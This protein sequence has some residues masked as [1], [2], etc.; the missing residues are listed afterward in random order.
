MSDPAARE[1]AERAFEYRYRF[2]TAEFDEARFQLYVDGEPVEVERRALEVLACLLRH[3]GE[4]V[5]K[6]ELFAQVWAGRVTVD[7][8]LPN[9]VNKLRKALG[10]ANAELLATQ[11]R[12]GYRLDGMRE[13]VVVRSRVAAAP[14]LRAGQPVAQRAHFVLRERLGGSHGNEVWLGEHLKT[15]ERRVYKY[16]AGSAGLRGLRR[17][18]TLARLLATAGEA[19]RSGFAR[20]LDWHFEDAPFFLEYAWHGQ[21]LLQWSRTHLQGM[22]RDQRLQLFLQF[23]DAVAAA[24]QFGVL[25]KDIKP[26]NILIAA[27]DDGWHARLADFGSGSLLDPGRL[28]ELGITRHD[29]AAT[30]PAG[31][32]AGSGT[33]LYLPPEVVAGGPQTVQGDVYALGLVLYQLLAG[34]P[35]RPMAPGWEKDIDDALLREDIALATDGDPAH[36]LASVPELAA[37]LRRLQRRREDAARAAEAQARARRDRE[38]L[39]RARARRPLVA[40]SMAILALGLATSLWFHHRA[41]QAG[42]VAQL[43]LEKATALNEFIGKDVIGQA[44]PLIAGGGAD[45]P[46]REVLLAARERIGPRFASQPRVAAA[47][48]ISLAALFNGI[49]MLAP[50]EDEV[51]KAL[52]LLTREHGAAGLETLKAQASLAGVLTRS[53]RFDEALQTLRQLD[54]GAAGHPEPEVDAYR[55]LAWGNYHGNKGDAERAIPEFERGARLLAQYRPEQT[56]KLD[57]VRLDLG[58]LYNHAERPREAGEL[59]AGLI[60]EI[61]R[62][63]RRNPLSLAIARQVLADARSRQGQYAQAQALLLQAQKD[64]VAVLGEASTNNLI[65]VR[66]LSYVARRQQDWPAAVRHAER[67]AEGIAARLGEG[68]VMAVTAKGALGQVLYLAGDQQR[69]EAPLRS[70]YEQLLQDYSAANPQTWQVG[71]WY[72]ANAVA[73][74]EWALAERLLDVLQAHAEAAI[75]SEPLQHARLAALRATT[76]A[77]RGDGQRAA[78]LLQAAISGLGESPDPEDVPFIERARSALAAATASR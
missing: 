68:H 24:H 31:S 17:E 5:T 34:D 65:L 35:G 39:L 61:G 23:A 22:P 11:P 13:R 77:A 57:S 25:H 8:V 78:P 32:D 76:L 12:L 2:G 73:R 30:R 3:A 40:A 47:M 71:F 20:L 7:K 29:P 62:R 16:A 75:G 64:I 59:A 42:R 19:T 63:P 49:E 38:A 26:A 53:G 4:V 46:V 44:N 1:A 15:G 36:R 6:E 74:G 69:A 66:S 54:R 10:A 41:Q 21:D 56:D 45:A 70:A 58:Q 51:R 60:E 14:L 52:V 33:P 18:A 27:A 55:A 48:H 9:A 72:A 28:D 37:R 43:E 67:F 50:A